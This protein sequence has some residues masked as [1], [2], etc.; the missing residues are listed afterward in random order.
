MLMKEKEKFDSNPN[1]RFFRGRTLKFFPQPTWKNISEVMS[2]ACADCN[3]TIKIKT[4]V[5]ITTVSSISHL[6]VQ[7]DIMPDSIHKTQ[8]PRYTIVDIRITSNQ[9][10]SVS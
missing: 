5:L 3:R 10:N 4:D 9:S 8:M 7:I 1:S 6:I 2:P